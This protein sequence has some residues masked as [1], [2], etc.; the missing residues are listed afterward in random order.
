[1]WLRPKVLVTRSRRFLKPQLFSR[2]RVDGAQVTRLVLCPERWGGGGGGTLYDG[3]YGE[4]P[5]DKG[6]VCQASG[7]WQGR[8]F[9]S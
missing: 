6:I 9:T 5:P 2:I 7:I 3:L 8:D 4:A 1:M